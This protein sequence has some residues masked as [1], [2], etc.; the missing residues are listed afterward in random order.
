MS[1]NSNE[2]FEIS[3]DIYI[4]TP[5]V[6]I[7]TDFVFKTSYRGRKKV[8]STLFQF[9]NDEMIDLENGPIDISQFDILR[10]LNYSIKHY[11]SYWDQHNGPSA[12][13]NVTTDNV[14]Y[15]WDNENNYY[16]AISSKAKYVSSYLSCM[17]KIILDNYINDY[18]YEVSLDFVIKDTGGS[19]NFILVTMK[20]FRKN[21][22]SFY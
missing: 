13:D 19:Q 3:S 6:N 7:I 15:M 8:D 16:A 22:D 4:N 10:N 1:S 2:E 11:D 21:S 18:T 9:F 14:T 5:D 12:I 20:W 17:E